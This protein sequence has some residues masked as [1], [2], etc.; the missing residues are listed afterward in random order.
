MTE[1]I[2]KACNL[3][4]FEGDGAGTAADGGAAEG[5]ASEP[6]VYKSNRK[7]KAGEFDNVQFG[8]Q[9][10]EDESPVAEE[11]KE[12]SQEER[13]QKWESLIKGEFK[14]FYTDSTQQ[15]INRRFKESKGLEDQ[16]SKQKPL[17]DLMMQKYGIA[18]GDV[19][20]LTEAMQND[21]ELFEEKA[22]EAGMSVEQYKMMQKL[23]RQNAELLAAQ[24]QREADD[25]TAQQTQKWL[26]EAEELRKVYS[27]FDINTEVQNPDFQRMLKSG[28]PMRH[29]YEVIHLNDI[30]AGVAGSAEQAVTANIRAKGMRP[31]EAGASSNSGFISKTDVS[32]LTRKE[33]AEIARRASQGDIIR[34]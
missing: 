20:K 8:V 24:K 9:T 31:K 18:D 5:Q 16:L 7:T 33:R 25:A 22:D 6:I 15:I 32:Q 4:L 34:F 13:K 29:A 26:N 3:N 11:K 27:G 28:V 10:E 14:D 1:I 21:D 30:K 19:A 23:E 17:I 12:V 2:L